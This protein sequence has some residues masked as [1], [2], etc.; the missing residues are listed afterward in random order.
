[1]FKKI[2]IYLLNRVLTAKLG[3]EVWRYETS[4]NRAKTCKEAKALFLSFVPSLSPD[5]VKAEFDK[6]AR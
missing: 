2:D 3:R 6:E 5:Q 4:T 1:M